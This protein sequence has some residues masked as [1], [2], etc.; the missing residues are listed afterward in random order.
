MSE[1]KLEFLERSKEFWNPGKTQFWQDV[2]VDL[3]IDH[4]DCFY[5]AW[6]VDSNLCPLL[7]SVGLVFLRIA[8]AVKWNVTT[9]PGVVHGEAVMFCSQ[10]VWL[11]CS[12][13]LTISSSGLPSGA[14]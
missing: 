5:G 11:S 7:G 4:G 8:V 14:G 1:E 13:P 10:T 6:M 3:V 9:E 12:N 2:G